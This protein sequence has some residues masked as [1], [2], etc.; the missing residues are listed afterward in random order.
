MNVVIFSWMRLQ[1]LCCGEVV[2][3]VVVGDQYSVALK[4]DNYTIYCLPHC[5]PSVTCP[6]FSL[7]STTELQCHLSC[8]SEL[9]MST[10]QFFFLILL[11]GQK[12]NRPRV[13][14]RPAWTLLAPLRVYS[15]RP[16]QEKSPQPPLP[17]TSK[18]SCLWKQPSVSRLHQPI[19][20][21]L[22]ADSN[23]DSHGALAGA[24]LPQ[25]SAPDRPNCEAEASQ[26]EMSP[27]PTIGERG[28][29][30]LDA[31]REG[32][33]TLNHI[34]FDFMHCGSVE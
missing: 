20:E 21:L 23:P 19:T 16:H 26:M 5:R 12:E 30:A 4:G 33:L 2:S 11:S 10:I 6:A 24:G 7:P 15:Q 13:E 29:G 18:P 31:V 27:A 22:L 28:G 9:I 1:W 25:L 14:C 3:C 32:R 8:L 34:K 17:H